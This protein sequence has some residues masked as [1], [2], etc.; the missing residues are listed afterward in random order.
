MA[1]VF[2]NSEDSR[3]DIS[4]DWDSSSSETGTSD[5][6]TYNVVYQRYEDEPLAD[7]I[8]EA[9]DQEAKEETDIDGLTPFVLEQRYEKSVSVDSW[10]VLKQSNSNV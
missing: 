6:E 5:N 8:N 4:Y 9:E 1:A 10:Y 7:E 3:S 2:Y